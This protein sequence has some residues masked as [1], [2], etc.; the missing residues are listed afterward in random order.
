MPL[1]ER[2]LAALDGE[3]YTSLEALH[4]VAAG[5]PTLSEAVPFICI[6]GKT[7]WVKANSQY[8]LASELIAGRLA[9]RARAGPA[10]RIIH[11]SPQAALSAPHLAG[12]VV[13]SE[14]VPNAINARDLRATGTTVKPG[15]LDRVSLARVHVFQT[16]IGVQDEQCLVRLSDGLVVSLDYG[17][18]FS[19]TSMLS[20]PNVVLVDI[21]GLEMPER[22][23]T[24]VIYRAVTEIE[25]VSDG[26]L[27]EA[28]SRMPAGESQRE[29][30]RG[31]PPQPELWSAARAR[32]LDIARWLAYR[33]GRL[34]EVMETWLQA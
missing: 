6:D 22:K 14:D 2:T 1:D 15:Q 25:G 18:A 29:G 5:S 34:R 9:A 26:E 10:T 3:G 16:W 12:L 23:N 24:A 20:D 11:V 19:D 28:V 21:A 27:I 31:R 33:R 13:G 17:A 4:A 8:G 30:S 7:Y 32:R